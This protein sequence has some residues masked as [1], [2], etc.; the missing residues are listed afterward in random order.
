MDKSA[1]VDATSLRTRMAVVVHQPS[2]DYPL[3][4]LRS[5]SGW[6]LLHCKLE[7]GCITR[8]SAPT[9]IGHPSLAIR[10]I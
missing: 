5:G 7:T 3:S 6:S 10:S 8:L 2:C 9:S 1:P 4:Q